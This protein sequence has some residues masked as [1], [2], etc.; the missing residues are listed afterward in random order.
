LCLT[1][2]N[3]LSRNFYTIVFEMRSKNKTNEIFLNWLLNDWI[4]FDS[5]TDINRVPKRK[6]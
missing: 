2:L 6:R 1:A 4:N 5:S 3:Q